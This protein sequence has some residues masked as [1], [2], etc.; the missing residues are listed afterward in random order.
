MSST[1]RLHTAAGCEPKRDSSAPP[2]LTLLY[3]PTERSEFLD[4]TEPAA[5]PADFCLCMLLLTLLYLPTERSEF[6]DLT[7]PAAHHRSVLH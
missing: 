4:L 6:L 1:L 2:L 5:D 7:Q 3:L